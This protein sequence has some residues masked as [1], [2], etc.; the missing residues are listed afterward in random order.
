MLY[1]GYFSL[2]CSYFSTN[3]L[4][5]SYLNAKISTT[6]LHYQSLL[7]STEVLN[8]FSGQKA[9]STW[10]IGPVK[11]FFCSTEWMS[12]HQRG[13]T[14]SVTQTASLNTWAK[15]TQLVP[16]MSRIIPKL[17]LHSCKQNPTLLRLIY[18][19]WSGWLWWGKCALLLNANEHNHHR[20]WS[21]LGLHYVVTATKQN[22]VRR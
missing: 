17:T 10:K 19:I 12:Q 4:E 7:F 6:K 8:L 5:M 15:C 9:T 14:I 3:L 1:W 18:A 13:K 16:H 20:C 22:A 2:T 21:S 11:A